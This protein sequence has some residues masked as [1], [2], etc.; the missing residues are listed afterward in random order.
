M[1]NCSLLTLDA[2][3]PILFFQFSSFKR[4][5]SMFTPFSDVCFRRKLDELAPRM[6]R[7]VLALILLLLVLGPFEKAL[8]AVTGSGDIFPN[9]PVEHSS[10]QLG[11]NGYG[12]LLIDDGTEFA[13][14]FVAIGSGSNGFGKAT[15][16]DDGSVWTLTEIAVAQNGV[17]Q[18]DVRNGG[19]AIVSGSVQ[20][21][22][23]SSGRGTMNVAGAGSLLQAN[24][25]LEL[26]QSGSAYLTIS[27]GAMVNVPSGLTRI[28][29][30]GRVHLDGGL[31]RTDSLDNRGIISGTGTVEVS[32]CGGATNLGRLQVGSGDHLQYRSFSGGYT[33]NQ[34]EYLIHGGEL[35]LLARVQNENYGE[36]RGLIELSEGTL[37]VGIAGNTFGEQQLI[38]QGLLA[39]IDGENHVY[40]T[41]RNDYGG[42]IAV[43]N[44]SLLM[45][46]NDVSMQDN[47]NISVFA[48]STAIFLQDL[49][50]NGGS[51]L[52]DLT[53]AAGFGHVEVV[54]D[55]QFFGSLTVNLAASYSPQLGDAFP[56][57]TVGGAITG[58]PSTHL[59]PALTEGLVWDVQASNHQLVLSVIQAPG[60]PGDFNHDGNIDGRDFLAWQRDPG[61]GDLAD[62][63]ANYGAPGNSSNLFAVPE[64]SC[65]AMLAAFCALLSAARRNS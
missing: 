45:F 9:P 13:S 25:Q 55:F 22:A 1:G 48:G 33:G 11:T 26:G 6:R 44:D 20:V 59:L 35:E 19:V 64:P 16:T 65:I 18:L 2:L 52:A 15:V 56:L 54:G 36:Q 49:D 60:L 34:G 24:S 53:G 28:G 32:C 37:R 57:V 10:V 7:A 5:V 47:S 3:L 46:H 40:G 29:G 12:T 63:Q 23:S 30:A 50:L 43:I 14:S 58:L 51:L 62:W 39:A 27:E 38:N 61:I 8:A 41:V 31:L 21:G 42:E 17:G 4:Y